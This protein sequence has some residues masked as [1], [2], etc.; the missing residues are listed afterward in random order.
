M[1]VPRPLVPGI[2]VAAAAMAAV[3]ALPAVAAGDD[4]RFPTDTVVLVPAPGA[5]PNPDQRGPG[6]TLP[7]GALH[8][9][10]GQVNWS[11]TREGRGAGLHMTLT[12]RRTAR[13]YRTTT[14]PSGR[15]R[16]TVPDGTYDLRLDDP[17]D[18]DRLW[19]WPMLDGS[20]SSQDG[21][22]YELYGQPVSAAFNVPAVERPR[23][24]CRVSATVVVD[25][26]EGWAPG[27]DPATARCRYL[28]GSDYS[29]AEAADDFRVMSGLGRWAMNGLEPEVAPIGAG[30]MTLPDGRVVPI[31]P[32]AD[33]TAR[34][35][36][37][38]RP[39]PRLTPRARLDAD[40]SL[41]VRVS[42]PAGATCVGRL[43]LTARATGKRATG[44][45]LAREQIG[46]GGTV[47]LRTTMTGRRVLR[48]HR[49]RLV[50]AVLAWTPAAGS[51]G[52]TKLV[53]VR[54]PRGR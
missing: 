42:C 32:P 52:T 7:T 48:R 45:L 12:D 37:A 51:T 17:T 43:T 6:M 16:M 36:V 4:I 38:P 35:P 41:R 28:T 39:A 10:F 18:P 54:V 29:Q 44:A 25:G 53:R 21:R 11:L 27:A 30:W 19:H 40:G 47:R 1:R 13:R 31:P 33:A 15:W 26:T 14:D 34:V 20:P 22:G 3:G 49:G 9:A 23:N 2:A 24:S 50:R 8:I 5:V 46:S